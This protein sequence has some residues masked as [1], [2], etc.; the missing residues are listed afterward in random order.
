MKPLTAIIGLLILFGSWNYDRNFPDFTYKTVEGKTITNDYFNNSNTLVILF[1]LGCP[2]A[3]F[4]LKDLQLMEEDKSENYKILLIAENTKSQILE[5][6]SDE[7]N[8]WSE[9][10]K[11]YGI[12]KL[13]YDII[14][15][16]TKEK[17]VEINGDLI[18]S[19]QCRNIAKKLRTKSSP[20]TFKVNSEGKIIGRFEGYTLKS[21]V[22]SLKE[23]IKKL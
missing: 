18:I 4:L 11:L 8:A 2:P 6:N 7:K 13:T 17:V 22:V 9:M 19:S 12:Q 3:M 23:I 15:E 16:C 10:R 21:N 1:H 5:F 20:T 14:G